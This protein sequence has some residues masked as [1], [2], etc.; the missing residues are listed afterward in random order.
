DRRSIY[1]VEG[2]ITMV[3]CDL[4]PT[5]CFFLTECRKSCNGRLR[6][7]Y[8]DGDYTGCARYITARAVGKGQV[9]DDLLPEE[10]DR[11]RDLF[12][13]LE[14]DAGALRAQEKRG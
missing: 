10:V 7:R 8:C 2:D 14:M 1:P 5:C 9:P 12:S 4:K 13:R 6:E 11:L 3:C